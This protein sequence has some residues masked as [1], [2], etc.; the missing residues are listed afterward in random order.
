MKRP[1]A[2][3]LLVLIPTL[4]AAFCWKWCRRTTPGVAVIESTPAVPVVK[5][6]ADAEKWVTINGRIIWDK[7][8]GEPP[9]RVPI[10]PSKDEEV[11]RKDPDFFTEDWIINQKNMG[12]KN[13]VIWLAPEP[14]A[15]QL[16]QLE[17]LK[18]KKRRQLPS[19]QKSDIHPSLA[20][21][22]SEKVRMDA[23]CCR[24]IPHVVVAR[25]GQD[26]E[27]RSTAPVP[28]NV[29]W[30]SYENG[31]IGALRPSD[32]D[33]DVLNLR[34]ERFPIEV[35]CSIHPWMKAWVRVFDHPYFGLTDHDG[36]FEIKN[37]PVLSGKLRIL[38]WQESGGLH[39]GAEGRFGRTIEVT[40]GMKDL[41]D[42]KYDTKL[43]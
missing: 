17:Q 1:L 22:S 31:P 26:F 36:R 21:P 20:E 32:G 24:F 10:L 34:A 42:I 12:I 19:F 8:K 33:L 29:K 43:P 39:G 14:T 28:H 37:A 15:E 6:D 41:G 30:T 9:K 25:E 40:G 18:E 13:V 38:I 3:A 27:F 16:Q 23:P 4:A 11:A 2:L 5:K 7:S 35:A